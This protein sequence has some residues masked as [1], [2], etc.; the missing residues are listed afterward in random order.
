MS[1][2]RYVACAIVVSGCISTSALAQS[3][4][5][6]PS[7]EPAENQASI[8]DIVVTAQKRSENLQKV[9]LSVSVVNGDELASRGVLKASDIANAIP[10]V[11]TQGVNSPAIFVRGIG[12]SNASITGDQGVAIHLDGVFQPRPTAFSAGMLD[13]ARIEVLKGPQGTLYGRGALGGNVNVIS[14]APQDDFE[15]KVTLEG[16]DYGL[17][18]GQVVLNVPVTD[19][20]AMRVAAQSEW[21]DGYASNGTDDLNRDSA[22]LRL[23]WEPTS[24][25]KIGINAFYTHATGYGAAYHYFRDYPGIDRPSNPWDTAI[26]ANYH[27]LDTRN[28]QVSVPIEIDL[29]FATLTY[30]PSVIDDR[31]DATTPYLLNSPTPYSQILGADSRTWAHEARLTSPA[32]Q[33]LEW[34]LGVYHMNEHLEY[35]FRLPPIVHNYGIFTTRSSS[36][37]GQVG[38][39]LTDKLKL[40]AGARLTDESKRQQANNVYDYRASWSPFSGKAGLQYQITDQSMLYAT[41]ANGFKAG[42]F[43]TAPGKNSFGPEKATTYEIGSK[44]RLDGGRFQINAAAYLYKYTDYQVNALT[45][46]YN[47]TFVQGVFNAGKVDLYGLDLETIFQPTP[48]DRI[49]LAG[50][51][52][53]G[54]FKSFSVPVTSG[55]VGD[56]IPYA[57][58]FSAHFGYE[59]R[60]DLADLGGLT[61]RADVHYETLTWLSLNHTDATRQNAYS[62]TDLMLTYKPKSQRFS[63]SGWVRNIENRAVKT[64]VT[65]IPGYETYILAPPR[66]A[67]ATVSV[68]F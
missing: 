67:G 51:Y 21:H 65:D 1:D 29:G 50:T 20:L 27:S 63:I 38:Y 28:W 47:G 13:V 2:L 26:G 15:G 35:D 64:S 22:R 7:A 11:N 54:Q 4:P 43:F 55:R 17:R 10:G 58:Q 34:T 33:R 19:K 62:R 41:V 49:E 25:I 66:T 37:F 48:D 57:P 53:H 6:Q 14:V 12:T 45:D 59:H 8:A 31:Y 30:I 3:V 32:G 36:V 39:A 40:I 16:G 23:Q 60:F 9:P 5:A 61:A 68:D 56:M 44:N 42:G 52:L 24:A 46:G 18:R